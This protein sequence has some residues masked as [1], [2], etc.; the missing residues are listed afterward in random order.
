MVDL[1]LDRFGIDEGHPYM[2]NDLLTG[3][4]Y[5][6]TGRRNYVELNPFRSVAHILHLQPQLRAESNLDYFLKP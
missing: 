5:T 1:P 4:R 3:A 2:V 6:W